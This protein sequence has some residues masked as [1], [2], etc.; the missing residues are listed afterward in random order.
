MHPLGQLITSEMARQRLSFNDVARRG[1]ISRGTVTSLARGDRPSMRTTPRPATLEG[2]S[3]GLGISLSKVR[4]EAARSAGYDPDPRPVG[5]DLDRDADGLPE[6][7][8]DSI[9]GTIRALR[10]ARGLT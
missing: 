4:A 7:D 5:Y 8:I 10:R 1:G 2:I 6:E 9:R 3:R